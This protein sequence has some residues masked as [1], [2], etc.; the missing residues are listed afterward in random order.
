M[1]QTFATVFRH[2]QQPT[3]SMT[4]QNAEYALTRPDEKTNFAKEQN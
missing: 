2:A 4:H 1:A 3:K